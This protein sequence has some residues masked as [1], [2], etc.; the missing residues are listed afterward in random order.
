[1]L[2]EVATVCYS[3]STRTQTRHIRAEDRH[4]RVNTETTYTSG[5]LQEGLQVLARDPAAHGREEGDEHATNDGLSAHER[6]G[7]E[8]VGRVEALVDDKGN[9][10]Q[11][12][13]DELRDRVRVRPAGRARIG[14]GYGN[15]EQ[16]KTDNEQDEADKVEMPEKRLALADEARAER[17]LSPGRAGGYHLRALLAVWAR[18]EPH[19]KDDGG[20]DDGDED[21]E[22]A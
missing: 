19:D 17:L 9:D 18:A 3:V 4:H 20:G 7:D 2:T 22:H 5:D 14:G 12:A 6:E 21:G 13:D 1:M 8:R 11:G 10:D 15:K 16:A